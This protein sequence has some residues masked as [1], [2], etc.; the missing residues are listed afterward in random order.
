M[1]DCYIA[2]GGNQG[3]VRETFDL[4]LQRLDAHPRISVVKTS[5]WIETTPVGSQ[6]D[7]VFLNG[8]AQL[9]VELSPEELLRELQSVE[10]E[11]GR[12]RHVRWGARTLDLDLLLYDQLVLEADELVIP[13]PACWYRRFV[14][15]PLV[16]IA[17]DVIHPVK[18]IS[19]SA[20]QQRLLK[21]PFNFS[22]AGLPRDESTALIEQLQSRFPEVEF[23]CWESSEGHADPTLIAW[24]GADD[25]E[26][27]FED[28]PLLP[29]ID[30]SA[31]RH[32]TEQNIWL[33]QSALD[34]R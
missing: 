20:L 23:S 19:I 29:R 8:A 15:D 4:A 18:Q 25:A 33:L 3:N 30:A 6:T 34:F 5:H 10:A 21:R 2:L 27:R 17:P 26:T 22:I 7:D 9:L 31:S 28:L 14:L 12:V 11:L 16:E 24:L 13:H 1:P 32:D